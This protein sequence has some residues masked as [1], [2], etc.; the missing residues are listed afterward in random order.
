MKNSLNFEETS[1][2]DLEDVNEG[3]EHSFSSISSEAVLTATTPLP[4]N[5]RSKKLQD[6]GKKIGGARKDLYG[7]DL[8]YFKSLTYDKKLD[9]CKKEK[10]WKKPDYQK[11]YNEGIPKEVLYFIKSI[12]DILPSKPYIKGLSFSKE[13]V[14]KEVQKYFELI[15]TL[16][17]DLLACKT[18][19]DIEKMAYWHERNGYMIGKGL[20][21]D[22]SDKASI[23]PAN[24]LKYLNNYIN[25]GKLAFFDLVKDMKKDCFLFNE[26]EIL[27]K[28]KTIEKVSILSIEDKGSYK[29]VTTKDGNFYYYYGDKDIKDDCYCVIEHGYMLEVNG[30]S[31]EEIKQEYIDKI[32]NNTTEKKKKEKK[33][34]DIVPPFLEKIE[35]IGGQDYRKGRNATP[36]MF[37]NTFSF[38]GGEFGNWLNSEDRKVS[39]NMAY[40]ALCDLAIALDIEFED[41]SLNHELGIGFGSRGRGGKSAAVAHYESYYKAINLTKLKG[42]GSLAHEWIHALDDIFGCLYNNKGMFS[43]NMIS[44]DVE[45]LSSFTDLMKGLKRKTVYGQE[46]I[47][48]YEKDL[49]KAK[50]NCLN[51]LQSIARWAIV[52]EEDKKEYKK[53]CDDVINEFTTQE[54]SSFLIEDKK[55]NLIYNKQPSECYKKLSEYLESKGSRNGTINNLW[56]NSNRNDIWKAASTLEKAK[57]DPS[58]QHK[59]IFTKFYEDAQALDGF[60]SK[61]YWATNQELLARAGAIYIKDKLE[62][63]G[64]V[65][66]YL[67]GHAEGSNYFGLYTAPQKKEREAINLLFDKFFEQLKELGYIHSK[68]KEND[69]DLS[70]TKEKG[71]SL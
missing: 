9:I 7:M 64:I 71:L 38:Y 55:G 22:W 17:D 70:I 6:F 18:I 29:Q 65:N 10:L 69:K 57:D 67:C 16:R 2:F 48:E 63:K 20:Y 32:K 51:G 4:F 1:L 34:L 44:L 15:T 52:N 8:D 56:A 68:D 47:A 59:T 27:L 45:Q 53:L 21:R 12:R 30:E 33:G 35:R 28:D 50:E 61:G 37:Q 54:Y 46:A 24:K 3:S 43:K 58:L 41:V 66:D 60:R 5:P 13:Y 39:L 26:E 31:E 40:D 25:R 11:L 36:T 62:Q 42:A 19:E 14:E 23:I 49:N